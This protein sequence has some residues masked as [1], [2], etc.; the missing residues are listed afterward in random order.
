MVT[1]ATPYIPM[2]LLLQEP[3]YSADDF[4]MINLPSRDATLAATS[5]DSELQSWAD[6]IAALKEDPQAISIGVQPGSADFINMALAFEAE[7]LDYN[8]MR[9]VTYSGGGP[10]RTAAAGSQ[11]DLAFVGAQGFIP[12]MSEITPL[13]LFSDEAMPAFEETQLITEYG[14]ENGMELDFVAGSQR[15]WVVHSD[16]VENHPDRYEIL[17]GAIERATKN[18]EGVA[19][20]TNQSLATTWAGPEASNR[21]Y[22]NTSRLMEQY[23]DL[24]RQ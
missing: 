22:V 2:S 9:V 3:N 15:G 20:L 7:G 4:H 6:V 21:A 8:E 10:L 11:V 13:V 16:F 1:S 17:L 14:A 12:L 19:D 24:L 18:P 5:A 23:A